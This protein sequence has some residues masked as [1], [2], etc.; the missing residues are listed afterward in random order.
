MA[1]LIMI[2]KALSLKEKY[3][4][5]DG[6]TLKYYIER[7][8]LVSSKPAYDISVE[9]GVVASAAVTETGSP[10]V[11]N[12]TFNGEDAGEVRYDGVAGIN[13][14]IYEAKGIEI[15]GNSML[16]EFSVKDKDKKIIGTVKKKIVFFKDT[17]DIEF[18]SEGDSLLFAML[19]LLIDETFHG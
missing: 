3:E 7:R 11:F 1:K 4:V 14:L 19:T 15:D 9:S 12:L 16:T 13:K 6:D 8:K 5:Y 10:L 18:V 2:Q 17:Y